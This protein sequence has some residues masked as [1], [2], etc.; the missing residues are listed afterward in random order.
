M[1]NN[2]ANIISNNRVN[3]DDRVNIDAYRLMEMA[4]CSKRSDTSPWECNSHGDKLNGGTHVH[5]KLKMVF[6]I[7]NFCKI[8]ADMR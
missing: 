7:H 2:I 1:S 5:V 4:Q 3:R 8:F 6:D